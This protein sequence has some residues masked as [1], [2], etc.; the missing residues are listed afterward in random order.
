MKHPCLNGWCKGT[1]EREGKKC[2]ECQ[3]SA[4]RTARLMARV[5]AKVRQRERVENNG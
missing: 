5:E 1:S 3:R 2:A 4:E